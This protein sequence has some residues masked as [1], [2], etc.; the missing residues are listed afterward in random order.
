MDC[1]IVNSL[2]GCW[3]TAAGVATPVDVITEYRENSAGQVLP[4]KIRYVLADGTI[5]VPDPADT[6]TF[7]TCEV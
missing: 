7:G 1:L 3:T 2:P 4:Y 5:V 6:V